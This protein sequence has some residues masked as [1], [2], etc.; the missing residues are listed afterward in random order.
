VW[1]FAHGQDPASQGECIAC[2]LAVETVSLLENH[3]EGL[4]NVEFDKSHWVDVVPFL[5][6]QNVKVVT[7]LRQ[8]CAPCKYSNG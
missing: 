4:F 5:L 3:S 2:Q 6:R 8:L 7:L 1:F